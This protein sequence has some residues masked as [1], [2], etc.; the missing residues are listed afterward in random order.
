MSEYSVKS[1][2]IKPEQNDK[3]EKFIRSFNQENNLNLTKAFLMRY[4]IDQF[5]E[6]DLKLFK[7]YITID[8][9]KKNKFINIEF[10]MTF[11]QD[12]KIEKI[13]QNYK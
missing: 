7:E 6:N 12:E 3:I 10:R 8:L 9:L 2:K 11:D 13:L 4:I 5:P 1:L